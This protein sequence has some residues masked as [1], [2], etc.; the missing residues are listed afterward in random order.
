MVSLLPLTARLTVW[1][2]PPA[3]A[4]TVIVRL[5]GSLA[6]VSV[7]A[8][9][10][11][12]LVVLGEGDCRPPELVENSTG[13]PETKLLLASRVI[14]VIVAVSEPSEG[15]VGVLVVSVS[16]PTVTGGCAEIT[17]IVVVPVKLP[18][19]A[20]IVMVRSVVSPAVTT[21]PVAVPSVPVVALAGVMPPELALKVTGTLASSALLGSRTKATT[22]AVCVPS[23]RIVARLL[24]TV[25]LATAGGVVAV[26]PGWNAASEPPPPQ[27]AS[28]AVAQSIMLTVR[29]LRIV[30]T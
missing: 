4:V 8:T 28:S 14:A 19:R 29:I 24:V 6:V 20:V 5:R 27:A 26:L 13:M 12:A 3:V 15:S 21:V 25:T 1:V 30:F 11:L 10:P 18:A 9:E 17:W 22:V 2:R 16:E 7:A 23:L